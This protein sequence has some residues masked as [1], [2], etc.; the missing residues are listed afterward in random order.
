MASS[1]AGGLSQGVWPRTRDIISTL[2]GGR[3]VGSLHRCRGWLAAPS[4]R[5]GIP[6]AGGWWGG[7]PDLHF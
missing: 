2:L 5:P 3:A 4:R 1:R 6:W 7:S